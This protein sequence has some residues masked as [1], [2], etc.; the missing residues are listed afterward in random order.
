MPG[1]EVGRGEL[2]GHGRAERKE[3]LLESDQEQRQA[4]DHVNESDYNP[5]EVGRALAQHEHLEADD[6]ADD[7]QHIDDGPEPGR[8]DMVKEFHAAAQ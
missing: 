7:R 4:E 2:L 8:V 3:R 6:H 5:T 1:D